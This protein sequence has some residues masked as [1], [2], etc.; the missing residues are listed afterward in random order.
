MTSLSEM[1]LAAEANNAA[2]RLFPLI[3]PEP[4]KIRRPERTKNMPSKNAASAGLMYGWEA[5]N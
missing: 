5:K 1:V 4:M 3:P 2:F